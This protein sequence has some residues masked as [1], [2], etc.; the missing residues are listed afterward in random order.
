M[1]VNDCSEMTFGTFTYSKD[2]TVQYIIQNDLHIEYH[3]NGRYFI[4]SKIIWISACQY[5]LILEESTLP[6]FT[7]RPNS[8]LY[9]TING[10][11][12]KS[13]SITQKTDQESWESEIIKISNHS[14]PLFHKTFG[15]YYQIDT[16]NV[17]APFAEFPHISPNRDSEHC[18]IVT[19]TYVPLTEM[20][21]V[22]NLYGVEIMKLK[23]SMLIQDEDA[24]LEF[25]LATVNFMFK[26]AFKAEII[27]SKPLTHLGHKAYTHKALLNWDVFGDVYIQS[28]AFLYK[29][30]IIRLFVMVPKEKENNEKVDEFF[31]AVQCN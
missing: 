26:A 18:K 2:T 17:F 29:D 14:L 5:K 10:I 8:E 27:E 7:Y 19:Y 11:K 31:Q 28:L 23:D 9:V 1:N 3:N 20:N 16:F 21:D 4:K 30:L 25:S 22:N 13:I 12:K 24:L 6:N 15:K